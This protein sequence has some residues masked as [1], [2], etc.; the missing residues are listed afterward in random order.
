[1]NHPNNLGKAI[2]LLTVMLLPLTR[3]RHRAT[4]RLAVKAIILAMVPL[5]LAQGRANFISIALLLIVWALL[6]PDA[7]GRR[8]KPLIIAG[9]LMALLGFTIIFSS[10]FVED[11]GGGVRTE[12]T[13]IA[14]EQIPRKPLQGLGPNSYTVELGPITGSYIPVHNTFLL[15][16]AEVGL[17]GM[18]LFLWP[19]ARAARDAW[20]RRSR[21]GPAGDYARALV[22]AIP[23]VV[24]I[25]ATGWGL[26]GSSM[27]TLWTFVT[28]F[29]AANLRSPRSTTTHLPSPR[30]ALAED[31][32]NR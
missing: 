16:A 14:L 1:M 4:N 5:G 24:L 23:G 13:A 32:T 26:L 9:S 15:L 21:I 20:R 25:G 17:I 11:P 27:L 12:L 29:C 7:S 6:L 8:I 10:R 19:F 2:F 30:G 22:A 3:S 28:A 18:A 31:S